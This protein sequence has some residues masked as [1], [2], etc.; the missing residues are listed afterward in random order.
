MKEMRNILGWLGMAEEES[1]LQDAQKHVEETYKT[2]TY[3]A[4]AVKAFIGGDLEAKTVAIEKVR[5]SEHQADIL[6]SKMVNELSE[7][8]LLPPDREDLMHFVKTLD[9]IA[10]WTNG[11]AR[12]LGFI[13][14]KLP[15]NVLKNISLATELIVSSV[16]KLKEGIQAVIKNDLKKALADS[17]AVGRLEHDADDQKK[18]LIE[19]IIHT[20]LEPATL[21]LSYQL[22]EYLEGVTDKIEDAADFIKVV[23][24]K[25]R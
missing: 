17:E 9:K 25:A 7:S 15:E 22:A 3:F 1:I 12:L 19:A 24:I 5:E 20:K 18:T 23:A 11:A 4:E 2:V 6:R 10:D 21:L 13:E 16:S 8:L 14:Q